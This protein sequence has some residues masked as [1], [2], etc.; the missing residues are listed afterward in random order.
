[1]QN[2]YLLDIK[3]YFHS[4][5]YT[6]ITVSLQYLLYSWTP[7][8]RKYK[9]ASL[10]NIT[11]MHSESKKYLKEELHMPDN[12]LNAITIH[13]WGHPH[14]GWCP[15][16]LLP[17]GSSPTSG[18]W[19]APLPANNPTPFGHHRQITPC[20]IR[21]GCPL[22]MLLDWLALRDVP[23]CLVLLDVAAGYPFLMLE[24]TLSF[25]MS[26]F[27]DPRLELSPIFIQIFRCS[28]YPAFG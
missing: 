20:D 3:I 28:T 2:E 24:L 13:L 22:F 12:F 14:C 10:T 9:L 16:T 11:Q 8:S 17:A 4:K 27:N 19:S 25:L 6:L 7:Y 1:M 5:L 15:A 26:A 21:A 18:Q 23:S